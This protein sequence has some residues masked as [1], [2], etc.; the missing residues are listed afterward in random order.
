M[1][2]FLV[3]HGKSLPKEINPDQGLSEEGINEV[4]RIAN[5]AGGYRIKVSAIKHSNKKRAR[6]TADI[7]ASVLKPEKGIM[8]ITGLKPLDDVSAIAGTLTSQENI[9]LVGHLPHL[10]KLT[11]YFIT[12]KTEKTIFKFQNG[13]I[14]CLD[15]ASDN[16]S[17]FIK[18]SL[19]PKID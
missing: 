3:Q 18:W 14:V 5:V 2:L 16:Q 15:K 8:E 10:E 9:M 1:P 19:M 4:N 17:W 12:G 7:L 11:S 13:G 6:Q